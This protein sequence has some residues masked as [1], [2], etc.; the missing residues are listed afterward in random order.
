MEWG[1]EKWKKLKFQINQ[2][3]HEKELSWNKTLSVWF[4]SN[5]FRQNDDRKSNFNKKNEQKS[6]EVISIRV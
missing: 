1:S 3:S 6:N 4:S 2:H 5:K